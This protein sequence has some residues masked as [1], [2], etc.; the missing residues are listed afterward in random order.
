MRTPE[1]KRGGV[2][3]PAGDLRDGTAPTVSR[4]GFLKLGLTLA[5]VV[6]FLGADGRMPPP[7]PHRT[8]RANAHVSPA[9]LELNDGWEYGRLEEPG[10]WPYRGPSRYEE[11]VLPHTVVRLSWCDW[12]PERWQHLWVYRREVIADGNALAGR[13]FVEFAGILTG[14]LLYVNGRFAGRHLG[15]YVPFEREIT[16]FLRPGKNEL[17]VVVDARWGQNVPP[18]RPRPYGPAS[19]D[20]WQP[21]G[22]YREAYLRVYPQTF[23]AYPFARPADVLDPARR[24]LEVECLIDSARRTPSPVHVR[25]E[26]LQG[27]SVISESTVRLPGLEPGRRRVHLTLASLGDVKLWDVRSPNLYDVALSLILAG[28]VVHRL[29]TRTGF[30]EARFTREG[31]FL[32]GR[33]LKL[34][35]LNRHQFYPYVGGAMPAR[36]Q[37]RDAEILKRELNCNMVRCSHYPQ[38]EAF[39]DACDELGLMV[40]EEAP[41][42]DY[43]GDASWRGYVLRDVRRMI[44]R[45]RNHPSIV[46]WGT[47]LNETRNDPALYRRTREIARDLDGSRPTTG[48]VKRAPEE[49]G[50]IKESRKGREEDP[51]STRSFAEDVFS[52]NDYTR[53]YVRSRTGNFRLPVLRPP[54]VDMPYLVSEAIGAI[55]GPHF[56]RR[57]DTGRVQQEQAILHAAVHDRAA[58]DERYCGLLAWSA[59]DY[60]SG[61]GYSF[62]GVK[63]T[64][65]CDVFRVPKPGAAFYR[66]QVD[67][68]VRPVI[69][70]AFYWDFGPYAPPGGPG[71][72][73]TIWSNCERLEVFVG[74]RHFA[75]LLPDRADFPHLEYPPFVVDLT[76]D[77]SGYPELRIDG[78]VRGRRVITRRFSSDPSGDRLLLKLDDD[79]LLAD[80]SDMTRAYFQV[81][82]RYGA[83]RYRASGRVYLHLSGPALLIGDNPFDLGANGGTG[84]VWIRSKKG[85]PGRVRLVARYPLLGS[86]SASLYVLPAG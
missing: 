57:I 11:A 17:A 1:L 38:S 39:L 27:G 69:E 78:Y 76:V 42:W 13:V 62:R 18:D 19:I 37:R 47:R 60:P 9:V 59:F 66:A 20:Y 65:V 12:R 25:A 50:G 75:S 15:G 70:P 64:G 28:R 67:P 53:K 85:A 29:Q 6:G 79:R 48:A 68:S 49:S 54:R 56:Y 33:R 81:V 7:A 80:G 22:I 21:G 52:F 32:N 41:G 74:G 84:A 8:G 14:A 86:S 82:D 46:I 30:R 51:Y 73:S 44:L 5:G 45:D 63:W 55:V 61:H 26:L 40:W 72:K 24:R 16:R 58:S 4:R 35:G 23:L 3:E 43:I 77:G 31:F 2:L 71:R 34:F 36:V 10:L 83:P